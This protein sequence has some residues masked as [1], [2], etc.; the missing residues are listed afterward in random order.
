MQLYENMLKWWITQKL[1]KYMVCIRVG[2][3]S[4]LIECMEIYMYQRSRSFFDICPRSFRFHYLISNS[5]FPEVTRQSD[6]IL[7][8]HE[9]RGLKGVGSRMPI[10]GPVDC[11]KT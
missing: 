4:K 10:I 6:Y 3:C 5:F 9:S 2:I 1:L 7:N 8:L 11:Q